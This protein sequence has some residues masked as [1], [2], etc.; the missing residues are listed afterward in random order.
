MK[1]WLGPVIFIGVTAVLIILAIVFLPVSRDPWVWIA[2]ILSLSIFSLLYRDNPFYKVAEHLFVGLAL[3]YGLGMSWHL[4][5]W[6][7]VFQPIFVEGNLIL[8]IPMA[9][10]LLYFTRLVPKAS[11]LVRIPIAF[12]LGW[13]SGVAIPR[14]F[15]TSIFEQMK[16]GVSQVRPEMFTSGNIFALTGGV[17][18]IVILLGTLATLV[19]FF[20][21]RR[22]KG[23]F[24]PIS[25]V[26]IF[27]IMLGFGATFGLTVMSRISLLI[28]RLQFLMKDWLGIIQ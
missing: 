24:K 2:A 12:A 21:S 23:I 8:L 15:Q 5:L 14:M 19:Y 27:F 3:G 11:W 6:P 26:G 9:I 17:W 25:Q 1:K 16:A 28:G 18:G 7:L 22:D 13:S 10:G 20:F 4:T